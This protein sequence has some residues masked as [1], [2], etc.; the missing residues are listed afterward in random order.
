MAPEPDK[1][2]AREEI[3]ARGGELRNPLDCGRIHMM[4][5]QGKKA[6]NFL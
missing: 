2:E 4:C 5:V 1:A 3:A 6:E